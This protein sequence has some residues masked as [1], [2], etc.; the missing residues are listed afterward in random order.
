[1]ELGNSYQIMI[2]E[3]NLFASAHMGVCVRVNEWEGRRK[4]RRTLN[5]RWTDEMKVRQILSVDWLLWGE[6]EREIL[7]LMEK[8]NRI[9]VNKREGKK[10]TG[11]SNRHY[12]DFYLIQTA[13]DVS[14]RC[15][16]PSWSWSELLFKYLDKSQDEREFFAWIQISA[17]NGRWSPRLIDCFATH[18]NRTT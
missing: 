16:S 9:D 5:S 6:W 1:M 8:K 18:R 12:F 7:Y 4:S 3:W 13:N 2:N 17:L 11:E 10:H 15:I 14:A